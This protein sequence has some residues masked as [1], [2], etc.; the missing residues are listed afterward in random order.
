MT[1]SP[2]SETLVVTYVFAIT[3]AVTVVVYLLRGF[4]VLTFLPGGVLWILI[5]LS[6]STGIVYG[7]QTTRR[8]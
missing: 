5:L 8:Y 3:L 6:I 7:V 2:P 4:G 1:P